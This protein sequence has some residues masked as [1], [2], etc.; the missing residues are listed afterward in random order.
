MQ[1]KLIRAKPKYINLLTRYSSV[2]YT[3]VDNSFSSNSLAE[4]KSV[5]LY[6][7]LNIN[8]RN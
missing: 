5:S 2:P 3:D 8:N 6:R 7:N 4:P 1:S